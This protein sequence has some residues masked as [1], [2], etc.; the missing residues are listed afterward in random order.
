MLGIIA[1]IIGL[2]YAF[3]GAHWEYGGRALVVFAGALL[4][5]A[6]SFILPSGTP[7]K[8]RKLVFTV[9]EEEIFNDLVGKPVPVVEE[10]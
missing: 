8:R 3:A 5:T 7:E 4:A 9:T 10:K 1:T 6:I 2:Y